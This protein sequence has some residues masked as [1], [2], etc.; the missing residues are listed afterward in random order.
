MI[1]IRGLQKLSLI[2]YPNQLSCI[3]F[4]FGCN[5]RCPYCHNPELVLESKIPKIPEEEFFKFLESRI[6][7]L[8]GVVITGGE[9]TL[10]KDL[11]SF[12]ERIKK[13]HFLVKLDTNGTNP[14]L[15]KKLLDNKI[16]DFVSMDIKAPF[17]NYNKVANTNVNIEK[18]KSSV[19]LLM[20][21]SIDYEFRTTILPELISRNDILQIGKE[22]SGCKKYFL[23]KFRPDITL[24]KE[25]KFKSPYPKSTAEEFKKLLEKYIPKVELR[26]Y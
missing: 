13:Q 18:V 14:E 8:D 3:V 11:Y 23:Q 16:I 1:D 4:L 10:Q 24:N 2:D 15:L 19:N 21:S 17:E 20:H 25:L 26:G 5:F 6:N 9:P 7:Y 22:I 12:I